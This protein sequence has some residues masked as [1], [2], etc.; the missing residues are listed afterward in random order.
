MKSRTV[1]SH[2]KRRYIKFSGYEVN[3]N[4]HSILKWSLHFDLILVLDIIF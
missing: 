2:K 4:A 1:H 3:S